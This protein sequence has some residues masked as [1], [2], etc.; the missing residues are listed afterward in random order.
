MILL[1]LTVARLAA[2]VTMGPVPTPAARMVEYDFRNS[3]DMQWTSERDVR[4]A[5][6][7]LT[8]PVK[9]CD[10]VGFTGKSG[11]RG[12]R[13][14]MIHLP[15]CLTVARLAAITVTVFNYDSRAAGDSESGSSSSST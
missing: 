2:I 6:H 8:L 3:R 12:R 15:V 5:N 11:G 1:C 4:G 13:V 10:A 7:W 14:T 9:G